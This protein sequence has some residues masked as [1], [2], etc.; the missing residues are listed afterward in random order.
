MN[1][2]EKYW[3][4]KQTTKRRK[5]GSLKRKRQSKTNDRVFDFHR[6]EFVALLQKNEKQKK[7]K[8]RKKK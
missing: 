1:G 3:Q 7:L 5:N 2:F 6:V 4:V 8:K